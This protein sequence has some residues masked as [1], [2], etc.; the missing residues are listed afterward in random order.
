MGKFGPARLLTL[1]IFDESGERGASAPCFCVPV[2]VCV[3]TESLGILLV[4]LP[5]RE[6]GCWRTLLANTQSFCLLEAF[7]L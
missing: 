2:S 5:T 4:D 6:T 7:T 1:R 3:E